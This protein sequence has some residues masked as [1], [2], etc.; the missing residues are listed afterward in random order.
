MTTAI[1]IDLYYEP[2]MNRKNKAWQFVTPQMAQELRAQLVKAISNNKKL[3]LKKRAALEKFETGS[4]G[5]VARIQ[6]HGLHDLDGEYILVHRTENMFYVLT[7]MM[8]FAIKNYNSRLLHPFRLEQ[9]GTWEECD[10]WMYYY[11]KVSQ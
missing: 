4:W 11:G 10:S 6:E 3:A 5:I 2:R 8:D 7:V 1:D 9:L